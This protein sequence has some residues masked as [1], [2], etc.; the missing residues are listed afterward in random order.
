MASLPTSCRQDASPQPVTPEHQRASGSLRT[1]DCAAHLRLAALP[2][3][4][5]A[6]CFPNLV[7][8]V[9]FQPGAPER[10]A[11]LPVVCLRQRRLPS[12]RRAS[13]LDSRC[14]AR[15]G[16]D[17]HAPG[18]TEAPF[19]GGS[20]PRRSETASHG[21]TIEALAGVPAAER[22]RRSR[23]GTSDRRG[24]VFPRMAGLAG[25]EHTSTGTRR[26]GGAGGD[27]LVRIAHG[28]RSTTVLLSCE[29]GS[30]LRRGYL[31]TAHPLLGTSAWRESGT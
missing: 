12:W 24:G 14:E 26:T 10:P 18:L 20:Y 28:T 19:L 22:A 23:V 27:G 2:L 15:W 6:A 30:R 29:E 3:V 9:R 8:L 4:T 25:R 21:K 31:Q 17:W 11:H 7:S 16:T 5:L 13:R 1:L